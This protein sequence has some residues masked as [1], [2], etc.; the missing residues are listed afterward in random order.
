MIKVN[1]EYSLFLVISHFFIYFS[2]FI[3]YTGLRHEDFIKW[4]SM[5]IS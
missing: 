3:E 4:K 5:L 2:N 1:I